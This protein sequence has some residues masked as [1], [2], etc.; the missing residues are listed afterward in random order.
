MALD[1]AGK[2]PCMYTYIKPNP[3]LCGACAGE[4]ALGALQQEEQDEANIS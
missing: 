4:E 2:G 3:T 1:D